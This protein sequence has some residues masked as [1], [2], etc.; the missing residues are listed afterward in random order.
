MIT[1]LQRLQRI[2][3]TLPETRSSAIEYLAPQLS[4]TIFIV[5]VL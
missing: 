3:N 4:Q 1:S 2:L 5:L